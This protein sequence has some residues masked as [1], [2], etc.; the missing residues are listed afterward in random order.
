MPQYTSLF[1][2]LADDDHHPSSSL[3]Y[4][5][6]CEQ[7]APH[8]HAVKGVFFYLIEGFLND[9]GLHGGTVK[10]IADEMG[11][12][13]SATLAAVDY[14]A[15]RCMVS[16]EDDDETR[17]LCPSCRA[18]RVVVELSWDSSIDYDIASNGVK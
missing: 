7:L 6:M 3:I 14:L 4:S 8:R 10:E 15:L 2:P 9:P 17:C 11:L 16:V 13:P 18:D 1:D 5:T 12:C